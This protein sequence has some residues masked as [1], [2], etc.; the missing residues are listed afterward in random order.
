[1]KCQCCGAEFAAQR[2]T[3][4]FCS[5]RCRIR[6]HRPNLV[7]QYNALVEKHNKL[8]G[9]YNKQLDGEDELNKVIRTLLDIDG[10]R[11]VRIHAEK[12]NRG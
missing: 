6:N 3:A 10:G 12:Q 5:S 9:E 11:M 4:K 8:V 2:S 7:T 1:M